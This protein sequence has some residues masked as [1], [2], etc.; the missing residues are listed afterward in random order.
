MSKAKTNKTKKA[1]PPPPKAKASPKTTKVSVNGKPSENSSAPMKAG[2]AAVEAMPSKPA[3]ESKLE[4]VIRLLRRPEGAT[5]DDLTAATGWQKHT[6][7][8]ALSHALAKKR[9]YQ[10][11][12]EKP[13]TGYSVVSN[14][15]E[16]GK[17]TYKI[18]EPPQN[19]H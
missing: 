12:S 11:V 1:S 3:K 4:M 17:R 8:A 5:I 15:P 10:I 16:S 13:T 6:V 2:L 9:G 14:K 19:D 18:A 7:R